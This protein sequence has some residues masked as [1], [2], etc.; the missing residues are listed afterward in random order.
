MG[1]QTPI[2]PNTLLHMECKT[3]RHL[4]PAHFPSLTCCHH[5]HHPFPKLSS[6]LTKPQ[7]PGSQPLIHP[8]TP[9]RILLPFP[10]YSRS[11]QQILSWAFRPFQRLKASSTSLLFP[12]LLQFIS[13]DTFFFFFLNSISTIPRL[14][15]Q[16]DVEHT[17]TL[18]GCCYHHWALKRNK[19]QV[20]FEID[21]QP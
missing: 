5:H 7:C 3:L 10:A 19:K 12:S 11:S 15:L 21:S 8:S 1:M 6:G 17:L 20:C 9:T 14:Y 4:T 13:T 2:G 18:F 16:T